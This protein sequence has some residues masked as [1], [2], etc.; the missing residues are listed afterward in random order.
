MTLA[1][2]HTCPR[3]DATFDCLRIECQNILEVAC[4]ACGGLTLKPLFDFVYQ[5]KWLTVNK[6]P[7]H[8]KK[9]TDVYEVLTKECE[10]IAH[11]A[12]YGPWRK[13]GY[14]PRPE[15]VMEAQCMTEIA[16]FLMRLKRD[17]PT[18]K[19]KR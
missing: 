12:W 9:K 2:L 6:L 1:H 4:A 14:F 8:P 5:G 15:I 18:R 7:R 3:C 13:Y 17:Q 16:Q 19:T 10:V 11:I